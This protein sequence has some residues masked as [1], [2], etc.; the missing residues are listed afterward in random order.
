MKYFIGICIAICC[1]LA[2]VAS[3]AFANECGMGKCNLMGGHGKMSEGKEIDEI[4]FHKAVSVLEN[5]SE[6]GL[7]TE[8]VETVK[9]L[10]Y[11]VK[12]SLIKQNADIETIAVDIKE[13]LGKDTIDANAV[14]KLIDQKYALKANKAKEAAGAYV[15]L[16]QTLTA[17]QLKKLKELH[18]KGKRGWHKMWGKEKEAAE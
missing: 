10:K 13:A 6:L 9:A 2:V 14:N 4:F 17:D 1:V 18:Q 5:A 15:K 12:K 11:S 3:S 8:Q 7:S 16:K